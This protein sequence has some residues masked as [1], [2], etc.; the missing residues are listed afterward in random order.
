MCKTSLS[1]DSLCVH[2]LCMDTLRIFVLEIRTIDAV[3]KVKARFQLSFYHSNQS[4]PK[5]SLKPVGNKVCLY[6][7]DISSMVLSI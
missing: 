2:S 6:Y 4:I 1:Y 3:L 5:A 7:Y